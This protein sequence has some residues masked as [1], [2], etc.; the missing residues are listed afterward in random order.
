[1]KKTFSLARSA[2]FTLVEVMIGLLIGVIGIIVIMQTFAVSEGYR[3][4]TTSGTDAQ[5][6]GAIAM[7]IMQ[8]ELRTAGFNMQPFH[9]I[10]CTSMIVWYNNLGKSLNLRWVPV[11]INPAGIPAG[12]ANTDVISI[13][14]GN[15]DTDVIGVPATQNASIDPFQIT[16]NWHGYR[17]GDFIVGVLPWALAAFPSARCTSSLPCPTPTAIAESRPRSPVPSR[18]SSTRRPSISA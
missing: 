5:V 18:C 6:N 1:M 12:D 13:T 4:T 10:G 16:K 9:V 11:E 17:N 14:Y 7:Y 2:G 15:A 3:R 8:N